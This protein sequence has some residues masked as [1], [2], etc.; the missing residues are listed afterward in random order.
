MPSQR[1]EEIGYGC[2]IERCDLVNGWTP[3]TISSLLIT[4]HRSWSI[5]VT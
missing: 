1:P 2:A 3:S 4:L 5:P